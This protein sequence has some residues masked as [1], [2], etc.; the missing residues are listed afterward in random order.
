MAAF[1]DHIESHLGPIQDGAR[2]REGVQGVR[3]RDRPN[4]GATTFMTL[5]LSNH[6][7]TQR[8]GVDVRIEFVI[9]CHDAFVE[10]FNSL[11]VLADVCDQVL[12]DHSAPARGTVFGPRGRFFEG[13]EMEALYC[14]SPVYFPD[15]LCKF[16]GFSEPFVPVWLVPITKLEAHYVGTNGWNSFE[17]LLARVDPNLLDLR[18]RSLIE[19]DA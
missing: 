10:G 12:P 6:V 7:L 2:L 17:E 11:S 8:S 14:A 1:I 9:A 18:R 4:P 16:G 19:S 5:G 15:D 13:S 3:F